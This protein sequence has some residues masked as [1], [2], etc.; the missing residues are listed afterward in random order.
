MTK[1]TDIPG[2]REALP[3]KKHI[4]YPCD[5]DNVFLQAKREVIDEIESVHLEV[6]VE[7]I[8]IEALAA[9]THKIYCEA[10]EKRFGKPFWTNGDYSKLDEPTKEYDRHFVR[11]AIKRFLVDY[12]KWARLVRK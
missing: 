11:W 8:D 12:S 4:D 2:A 5:K 3:K 6:D 1:L 7:A 9:E 10:Y